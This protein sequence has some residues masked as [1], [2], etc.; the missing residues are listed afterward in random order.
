MNHQMVLNKLSNIEPWRRPYYTWWKFVRDTP[1]RARASSDFGIEF[2][3]IQTKLIEELKLG[4]RR[5]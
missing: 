4:A 3:S 5:D 1:E 2:R